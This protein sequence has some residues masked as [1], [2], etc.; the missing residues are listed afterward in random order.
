M[1]PVDKEHEDAPTP[2]SEEA[3]IKP[4]R[5]FSK[6]I[7]GWRYL[8][9]LWIYVFHYGSHWSSETSNVYTAHVQ[10]AVA[11]FMII[12]G[13]VLAMAYE[14]RDWGSQPGKQWMWFMGTRLARVYPLY[15]IG[16][17]ATLYW[18]IT[19][20]HWSQTWFGEQV[21]SV[22]TAPGSTAARIITS[23]FLCQSWYPSTFFAVNGPAWFMSTLFWVWTIFPVAIRLLKSRSS[24]VLLVAIFGFW[25]LG[26]IPT[27]VL[28][29]TDNFEQ[30]CVSF[31]YRDNPIFRVP[32]FLVG[33]CFGLLMNKQQHGGYELPSKYPWR[34]VK[35][36]GDLA[37]LA[38]V[39]PIYLI[40]E[41]VGI[42]DEMFLPRLFVLPMGIVLYYTAWNQG[43]AASVVSAPGLCD[44]GRYAW[45]IYIL[46][47]AL[48]YSLCSM[49][50]G[51]GELQCFAHDDKEFGWA[52]ET[53]NSVAVF[54][55]LNI[56]AGLC[57]QW[58]VPL[59]KYAKAK[60]EEKLGLS[61]V[62]N[63]DKPQEAGDI[64]ETAKIC[65]SQGFDAPSA[66][67]DC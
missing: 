56:V 28:W 6:G 63:N 35:W 19:E 62:K 11:S 54:L 24:S 51:N 44:L 21:C 58:E 32:E 52:R 25:I 15:F 8:M 22:E 40:N 43:F 34:L 20:Q 65:S 36:G 38:I 5:S 13:F 9:A 48:W 30:N 17:A 41:F 60:I 26:L 37:F 3:V 59:Y 42:R 39:L 14:R 7:E 67:E 31:V 46:Q 47:E 53:N 10:T 55:L 27:I 12:S 23:L 57:L 2:S 1:S 45:G 64:G 4:R 50:T 49:V 16:W 66:E 18:T 29:S 33:V 61:T